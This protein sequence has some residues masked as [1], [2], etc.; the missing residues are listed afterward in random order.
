MT[1]FGFDVH[2][3][4]HSEEKLG[5]SMFVGGQHVTGWVVGSD[6]ENTAG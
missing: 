5:S 2:R 6:C 4:V 1:V 3:A